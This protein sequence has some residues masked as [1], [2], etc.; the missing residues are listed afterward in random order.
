MKKKKNS[1][2]HFSKIPS[3]LML[4]LWLAFL[5]ATVGWILLASLSTTAEIFKG[6]VM[7][8]GFHF[9]NYVKVWVNNNVSRYFLNSL[10][11]TLTA[12]T[13]A[14]LIAAPAAYVLGRKHFRGRMMLSNTFLVSMSVP[15]V[16][17]VIPIFSI[18]AKLGLIGNIWTLVLLYIAVNV[19]YTVYFLTCFFS[20]VPGSLEEAA[21][22]DGCTPPKAFWK[23]ILP[24]AQPGI[25]TVTI[26][27]FMSI[28]N[29]Y[30]MALIFANS[31]DNTRT[32]SVGLQNMINAMKY[33][34][35]WAG[36]FAAVIIVF[37]PTFI[38]YLFLSNRIIAGV[39]GGAVKG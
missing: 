20:T 10:V 18:C 4:A 28:W 9:E 33:S 12:C 39:T 29:E 7:H 2:I 34:G 6:Q 26:F 32:L 37:L 16:M 14:I 3:Y 15:G 19:P 21:M 22:I 11:T 25:I 17:I 8:T 31:S 1:R 24:M 30:F 35:D 38:L 5:V 27:N 23:I 13:A 36:L